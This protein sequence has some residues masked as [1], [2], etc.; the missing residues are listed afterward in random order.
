MKI[1]EKAKQI[2]RTA[3]LL[4]G[5]LVALVSGCGSGMNS[6]DAA[7]LVSSQ[8]AISPYSNLNAGGRDA[9]AFTGNFLGLAG[10]R[11]ADMENAQRIA[12]G[13]GSRLIIDADGRLVDPT[14]D[15]YCLGYVNTPHQEKMTSYIYNMD[16]E[17]EEPYMP[18]MHHDFSKYFVHKPG[19]IAKKY[20]ILELTNDGIT[21]DYIVET[22]IIEKDG[23]KYIVF[24]KNGEVIKTVEKGEN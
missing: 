18:L 23:K 21:S 2:A 19:E 10:Q 13:Q 6:Y 11:Q 3:T 14:R 7:G 5:G 22:K 1:K 4:A 24:F 16:A 17:K 20:R 15:N 8:A 9:A 12:N